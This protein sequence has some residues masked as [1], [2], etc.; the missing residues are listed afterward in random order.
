MLQSLLIVVA[1]LAVAAVLIA[2]AKLMPRLL[3]GLIRAVGGG[4]GEIR[5]WAEASGWS[6]E[7]AGAPPEAPGDVASVLDVGRDADPVVTLRLAQRLDAGAEME[8][9]VVRYRDSTHADA[10]VVHAL[11]G[12]ARTG[13]A[14]PRASVLREHLLYKVAAAMGVRDVAFPDDPEFDRTFLV[15]A[16]DAPAAQR[17][18]SPSVRRGLLPFAKDGYQLEFA[19]GAVFVLGHALALHPPAFARVGDVLATVV[20]ALDADDPAV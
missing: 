20:R 14:F 2:L 10:D 9:L 8:M 4:N 1:L 15:R 11:V 6:F 7:S 3:Q 17:L 18:L 13:R 16:P 19:G 12:V 5:A